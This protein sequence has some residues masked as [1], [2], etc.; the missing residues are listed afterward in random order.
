[1][2]IDFSK[3]KLEPNKKYGDDK[4]QFKD[5][6]YQAWAQKVDN[7]R[8]NGYDPVVKWG[9]FGYAVPIGMIMGW[10]AMTRFKANNTTVAQTKRLAAVLT[11]KNDINRLNQ[12]RLSSTWPSVLSKLN[13]HNIRN[14][15]VY[16]KDELDNSF[17][18][19]H[20]EYTGEDLHG[21]L[22]KLSTDPVTSD[23]FDVWGCKVDDDGKV[24]FPALEEFYH[25]NRGPTQFAQPSK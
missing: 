6:Y 5:T 15:T 13:T 10:F 14:V 20:L 8:K 25:D 22:R 3:P 12:L 18:F 1:M 21:D 11:N 17:L 24:H 16:R 7:R 9:T 23:Y 19:Q 4:I 2:G